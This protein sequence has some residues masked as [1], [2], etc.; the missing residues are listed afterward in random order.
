MESTPGFS[1]NVCKVVLQLNAW[2]GILEP[3]LKLAKA[4]IPWLIAL[5]AFVL[6]VAYCPGLVTWLPRLMGYPT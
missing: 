5:L 6:I 1:T 3:V 4:M 2:A